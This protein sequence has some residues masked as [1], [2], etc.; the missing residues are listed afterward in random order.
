MVACAAFSH[1]VTHVR[2]IVS[3]LGR[4]FSA[5]Y[6]IRYRGRL[7]TR[8]DN[9]SSCSDKSNDQWGLAALRDW[10]IADLRH[11]DTRTDG[12]N[13]K[14]SLWGLQIVFWHL[15]LT[16]KN[17]IQSHNFPHLWILAYEKLKNDHIVYASFHPGRSGFS[18]FK[19]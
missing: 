2:N 19:I 7:K 13:F 15:K 14:S 18:R 3:R 5:I 16:I 8:E 9:S 4:N 6:Y 1:K 12:W 10:C 17:L 11:T